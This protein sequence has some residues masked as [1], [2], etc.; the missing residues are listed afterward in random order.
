MGTGT[1]NPPTQSTKRSPAHPRVKAEGQDLSSAAAETSVDSVRPFIRKIPAHHL[2]DFMEMNQPLYH[3]KP[4]ACFAKTSTSDEHREFTACIFGEI[5]ST[6]RLSV[7]RPYA[8]TLVC[9]DWSRFGWPVAFLKQHFDAQEY[10]IEFLRSLLSGGMLLSTPWAEP[11]MVLV[12]D[13][14]TTF[15][16]HDGGRICTI[17]G[18]LAVGDTVM[19]QAKFS[20]VEQLDRMNLRI[21]AANIV[22][23]SALQILLPPPPPFLTAA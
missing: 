9:P 6:S 12:T 1:V 10:R 8:F 14:T 11:L 4:E 2:I 5:S 18:D 15:V 17:V 13:L 3:Y 21:E 19:V 16:V 20:G 23:V 7:G 22:L